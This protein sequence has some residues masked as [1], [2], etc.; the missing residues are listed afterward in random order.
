MGAPTIIA[1]ARY[2]V[3][4]VGGQQGAPV[5]ESNEITVTPG[6]GVATVMD[7][8]DILTWGSVEWAFQANKATPV[9]WFE[10]ITADHDG[11]TPVWVGGIGLV[12]APAAGTYD[13]VWSVD[14]TAGFM[15]FVVTPTSAG[16]TFKLRRM[17]EMTL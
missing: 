11:T 1:G 12:M 2:P 13:F 14:I 7:S 10:T 8:L 6:A 16:W 9:R 15:R 3:V 17:V 4:Q 5:L